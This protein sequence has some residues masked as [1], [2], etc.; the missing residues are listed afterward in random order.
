MLERA[1]ARDARYDGRFLTGVTSTG[2]YCLPSC[3]ARSPNPENVVHFETPVEARAAGLRACLRC[4]PDDFYKGYD[5]DEED[6]A[7]VA[8]EVVEAPS[9]F[10]DARA[11]AVRTG[12]GSTKL[13]AL[14]RAHF[15]DTPAS[16]LAR[17]RVAAACVQLRQGARVLDAALAAG[18]DSQSAF[19]A[20]FA[21]RVGMTPDAYR[22]LAREGEFALRLP[23]DY[24]GE[25]FFAF[26][27]RD[28]Q[29]AGE[30]LA[31][32]RL[33]KA[34]VLAGAPVVLEIELDRQ[35]ARCRVEGA[36]PGDGSAFAA[37]AAAIRMLGLDIDPAPFEAR[38]RRTPLARLV[39]C[40]PGL[41]LPGTA[42][43]FEAL[44][45]T[46]VGQQV[47]VS[48]AATL[49][50]RVLEHFGSR[51]G[52]MCAHPSPAQLAA[53]DPVDLRRLQFSQRKA[54]YLCRL[55]RACASGD[56]DLTPDLATPAPR[57]YRR[58]VAQHGLGPW[59][60]SYALL[61]GYGFTDCAPVE[62]VGLQNALRA[63]L[64]LEARPDTEA[65]AALLEP[66]A[67]W[68][69]LAVYH[70]W[71]SLAGSATDAESEGPASSAASRRRR[72]ARS[73]TAP[74]RS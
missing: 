3:R 31:G 4:R 22:R 66:Y 59:S 28:D 38:A 24:R 64:G 19:Y 54:E 17:A 21:P 73:T 41:R 27:G 55:A 2:I 57:L 44:V 43:P 65:A 14:F 52:G 36:V 23:P 67:P 58:I 8:R 53:V 18:F 15:H 40:R 49:R 60:A 1:R 42:D 51:V 26:H 56:L 34:L 72:A 46:V 63:V 10:A 48:F 7:A 69:S 35:R 12:V 25:E 62:D 29:G 9:G 5:P 32:R 13:H 11:L 71:A 70:L 39:R 50:R 74:S 33:Q 16:F 20:N 47:N 30:R 61:R 37:H 45:W 68:R 6:A